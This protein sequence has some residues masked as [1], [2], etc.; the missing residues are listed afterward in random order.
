MPA[1]SAKVPGQS[2]HDEHEGGLI[3]KMKNL[4]RRP[5]HTPTD[6]AIPHPDPAAT[7]SGDKVID[8]TAGG[9][10]LPSAKANA[11]G[12]SNVNANAE[13]G[14]PGM[15]GGE[16]LQLIAVPL[17]AIDKNKV[18]HG[19]GKKGDGYHVTIPVSSSLH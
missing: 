4:F 15:V 14:W 16:K 5:S 12:A 10:Q 8:Q 1:H 7:Q 18:A 3:D 17:G 6:A 2:S 11:M 9:D 19:G 13:S